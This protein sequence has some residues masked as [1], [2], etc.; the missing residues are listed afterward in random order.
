MIWSVHVAKWNIRNPEIRPGKI[1][2]HVNKN[3]YL[4]NSFCAKD[5]L[6]RRKLPTL[7][8]TT[9]KEE[10]NFCEYYRTR[11]SHNT[12]KIVASNKDVLP[13]LCSILCREPSFVMEQFV[14]Q[15]ELHLCRWL[16]RLWRAFISLLLTLEL[17]QT[18]RSASFM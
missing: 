18:K 11:C 13:L 2:W 4:W 16:L 10:D 9:E 15:V 17:W 14:S 8:K 7:L 3:P 6:L 1:W 12:G 5:I